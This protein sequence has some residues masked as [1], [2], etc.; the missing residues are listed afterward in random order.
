LNS[1]I[2]VAWVLAY[3]ATNP[4]WMGR[5]RKE[6]TSVAQKYTSNPDCPLVEQLAEI[7]SDAWESEFP[8]IHLCLRDSIRLQLL[9]TALR[10]NISG[11]DIPLGDDEVIPPGA[12]VCYH[13]G[14]IHLNPEIYPDPT[15]WDPSR[16]LP[17]RAEDKKVLYAWMGWG[18]GRHPC[19]KSSYPFS[20]SVYHLC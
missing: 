20:C 16:Y 14:D 15:K 1:G 8:M 17:D 2:N 18:L 19:R 10:R 12:F 9:G 5:V 11:R 13:V 6:I 4:E 7:P 3:L